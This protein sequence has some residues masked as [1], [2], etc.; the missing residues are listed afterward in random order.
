MVE[1]LECSLSAWGWGWWGYLRQ[2]IFD[3]P[4]EKMPTFAWLFWN[5]AVQLQ[6]MDKKL[7]LV[8]GTAGQADELVM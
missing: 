5:T 4:L 2:V 1:T 6:V 3:K 7:V 8:I